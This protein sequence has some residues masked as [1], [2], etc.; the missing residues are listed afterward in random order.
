MGDHSRG[1]DRRGRPVPPRSAD[2]ARRRRIVDG[3]AKA[4]GVGIALLGAGLLAITAVDLATGGDPTTTPVAKV[5]LMVLFG[6][7]TWWGIDIGWPELA[8][9][10]LA[11]R[12]LAW[13]AAR[14]AASQR[15]VD[16]DAEPVD[17]A[18]AERERRVLSLA[19]KEQGRVT[20][21]EAAGRCDLTV[22]EAKT[23]LD[24]LVLRKIAQLHVS[25]EGVL[26]YVFPALLPGTGRARRRR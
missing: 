16:D 17:P 11:R 3:I 24:G 7:M 4:I 22:D 14:R 26:V 12:L 10:P 8:P 2:V 15:P 1:P 18:A 5:G 23:L 25:E 19:E 13:N 6:A 20:V 9:R 21:L